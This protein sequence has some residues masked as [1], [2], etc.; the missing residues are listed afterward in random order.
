MPGIVFLIVCI[1]IGGILGHR[2]R[3]TGAS[4]GCVGGLLGGIFLAIIGGGIL[5]CFVG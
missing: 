2:D 1:I 4:M 3:Y 5:F